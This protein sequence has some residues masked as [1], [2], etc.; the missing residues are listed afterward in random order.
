MCPVPNCTCMRVLPG[1]AWELTQPQEK[2]VNTGIP[3]EAFD[4]DCPDLDLKAA[5]LQEFILLDEKHMERLEL[6]EEQHRQALG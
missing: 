1:E 5:I 2:T 3:G 6:M 4:L